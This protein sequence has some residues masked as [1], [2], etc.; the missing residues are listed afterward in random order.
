VTERVESRLPEF[1]QVRGRVASDYARVRRERANELLLESLSTEYDVNVDTAAI[2][3]R[4]LEAM[5]KA[6]E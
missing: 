1:E 4:S 3:S 6:V 5:R 2:R